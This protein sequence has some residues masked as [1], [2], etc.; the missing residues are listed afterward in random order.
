LATLL[1]IKCGA[2]MSADA[3]TFSTDLGC[4]HGHPD[5]GSFQLYSRGRF[6]LIDPGYTYFKKTA[7]HNTLLVKG[8][9]QLGEDEPWFAA[10][11]ALVF[12]H[13]PRILETRSAARY[14]YILADLAPAYHPALGLHKAIR[15]LLFL[16]PDLLLVADELTVDNH[17]VLYSFPADTLET[18]GALQLQ[19]GYLAGTHGRAS[20]NFTGAARKYDIAVSYLD[21]AP[22][23]GNY[24]L[25]VDGDTA[26]AWQDT[27]EITDTHLE[28]IPRVDLKT[29]SR[30]SFSA[31]PMGEGARLVKIMVYSPDASAERDV[32][33]L[34]NF[35]P[36]TRIERV[37][38]RIEAKGQGISLDVYPLAPDQR[39]H[40]WSLHP[41]KTGTQF[42]QTLQLEIKPVFSDSSSTLL[43]L[44]HIRRENV[45]ALE[46]LRGDLNGSLARVRWY[47][48][49]QPRELSLDLQSH[50]VTVL[51]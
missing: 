1:G 23:T 21:N 33:W 2:F 26:S 20:F 17:G 8:R 43:N 3:D 36:A 12:G 18:E 14:H 48:H 10:A 47:E 30:V 28:I 35:D 51:P 39:N 44:L 38:T 49:G 13:Q 42:E 15:H 40:N 46:W 6:L 31:E 50:A 25:L 9:G 29:G 11:E 34:L 37:S 22:N 5:A 32:S 7:N 4:A 45:S 19:S 41:V 27:V 16:K 24:T